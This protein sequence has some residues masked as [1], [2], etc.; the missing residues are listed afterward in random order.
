[1]TSPTWTTTSAGCASR[2]IV[3]LMRTTGS[4]YSAERAQQ[5]RRD[6]RP[7][8]TRPIPTNTAC[9]CRLGPPGVAVSAARRLQVRV[10]LVEVDLA[11]AV[12]VHLREH[13]RRGLV[14]DAAAAQH[15][16][17]LLELTGADEP[18]LVGVDQSEGRG[19]LVGAGHAGSLPRCGCLHWREKRRGL[20]P[21]RCGGTSEAAI[22]HLCS[23]RNR[24]RGV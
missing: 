6:R 24:L 17:E 22:D 23:G 4:L 1:M 7:V 11:V 21:A 16:Q 15:V 9:L 19:V 10:E 18:V 13:G 8:L 12:A 14:G 20:Y 5:S 2:S 3:G